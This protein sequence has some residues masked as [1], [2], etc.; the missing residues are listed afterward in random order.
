MH[1]LTKR[2]LPSTPTWSPPP[3]P[4]EEGNHRGSGRPSKSNSRL[5]QSSTFPTFPVG[6]GS[7]LLLTVFIVITITSY[8]NFISPHINQVAN[9][10][11]NT[12]TKTTTPSAVRLCTSDELLVIKRQLPPDDC[13]KY[14]KKPWLQRCSLTY[15]TRCPDAVWLEKHYTNLR[16]TS[17]N[18]SP[19]FLAVFVGCNKGFDALNALRMGSGNP[20]FDKGLWNDAITQHGKLTLHRYV[21]N[22]VTRTQF[23][24]PLENKVTSSPFLSQVHCI[25]PMPATARALKQAAQETKYDMMG[26]IVSHAALSRE[27][28]FVSF[29]AD[30]AVGVENKGISNTNCG[31]DGTN[32]VNVTK[33]SLDSY[34][35]RFVPMD[36][37]NNVSPIN[38]LSVDV[39]GWD[40]EVLLGGVR[41]SLARVQYLEFEYNWVGPWKTRPLSEVI[42]FLDAQFGFTCY[43]A[44]FNNTIWRITN[45]WLDHYES[46]FWSNVACVNRN[47]D[48]VKDLAEDMEKLFMETLKKDDDAVRNYEHRFKRSDE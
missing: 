8:T 40:Y 39:E 37:N 16:F 14:R 15:A 33:Y 41:H 25:E 27:N 34:V 23:D 42:Q 43:W 13:L 22:E 36:V 1:R 19:P 47:I 18:P 5:S 10:N 48:E 31:G 9:I 44:G 2:S 6:F 17:G 3:P 29:S 32:C 35:E 28:G 46:H 30:G 45:C 20:V 38:Y 7:L 26:F 24:L 12:L 4:E 11:A 21:C